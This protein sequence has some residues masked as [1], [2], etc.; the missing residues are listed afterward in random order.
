MLNPEAAN[1]QQRDVYLV[2]QVNKTEIPLD[3]ARIVTRSDTPA[4]RSYTF[5][6]TEPE[7]TQILL[8]VMVP[9]QS[10]GVSAE[11]ADKLDTFESILEQYAVDFR[12]PSIG[13]A[14]SKQ[15][16]P[17]LPPR[18]S[19]STLGIAKGEKD[20][21]GHLI[22]INEATG[23]IVGEIQDKMQIHEDPSMYAP[24]HNKDPVI[25]EVPE[26]KADANALQAF[27]RLVPPDQQ[28]WITRSA[29]ICR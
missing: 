11:L 3:P 19:A 24:G 16:A 7:P 8:R 5:A 4:F 14:V 22:M 10:S 17:D 18:P 9:Q 21:R 29:S 28:N 2:L 20:F 15:S 26:G 23:E 1:K 13:A 25:I 12:R 6:G 27:A